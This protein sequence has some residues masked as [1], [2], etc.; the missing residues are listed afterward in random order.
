MKEFI[1]D[2]FSEDT[3]TGAGKYSAKR[4]MGIFTGVLAGI[5]STFAGLHWYNVPPEVLNPMWIYSG[6]MLGISILKGLSGSK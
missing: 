2:I 4:F 5:G 1:N 3:P 6:S